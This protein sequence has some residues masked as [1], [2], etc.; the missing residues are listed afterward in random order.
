MKYSYTALQVFQTTFFFFFKNQNLPGNLQ[1]N[2]EIQIGNGKAEPGFPL[3][4]LPQCG[5][6]GRRKH[7]HPF[8]QNQTPNTEESKSKMTHEYKVL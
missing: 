1:C 7:C 5:A 4:N 3:Q 2:G 6:Q 8:P